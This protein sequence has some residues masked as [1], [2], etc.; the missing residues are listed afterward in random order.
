MAGSRTA[1][2]AHRRDLLRRWD[3]ARNVGLDPGAFTVGSG[4]RVWW[5]CPKGP[6]HEFENRIADQARRPTACPFCAG[7][8]VSVTNSLPILRPDLVKEWHPSRNDAPP[9]SFT[10]GSNRLVWWACPK[11]ADHEWPARIADRSLKGQGC[12]ACAGKMVSVTNSLANVAPRVA[13]EW[14]TSRNGSL[15]PRRSLRVLVERYG[16][17]VRSR[18]NMPIPRLLRIASAKN[19]CPYCRG[20]KVCATN[21]LAS[22]FPLVASEWH[23][24][25]NHSLTP[26]LVAS[27]SGKRVWWLCR[28]TPLGRESHYPYITWT[29]LPLLLWPPSIG[30]KLN[31]PTLLCSRGGMGLG[32]ERA[33]KPRTS[34]S[35]AQTSAS[36]GDVPKDPITHGR[37]RPIT[38]SEASAYSVAPIAGAT[39]R[40]SPTV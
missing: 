19:G 25:K 22:Q 29:W 28:R 36:G 24:A 32:K 8:R 4:K 21:S 12:P 31:R 34:S 39:C 2:V 9:S 5:K 14:H 16:G 38:G 13:S 11:G 27:R 3:A 20:L 37:R 15:T 17:S 26:H 33:V 7:K 30:R 6:D 40:L 23:P 1:T 35:G 18:Q 10:Y